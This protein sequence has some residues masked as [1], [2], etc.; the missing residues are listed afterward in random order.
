MIDRILRV[1]DPVRYRKRQL[2]R[3]T[4]AGRVSIGDHSYG[5][6]IL[7]LYDNDADTSLHIG[8]YCSIAAEVNILLG[9]NHP[10]DRITTFPLRHK[11]GLPGAGTDG[12]PSSKGD[13]RIGNDV[14][15]GFGVT[16]V[17]GVKIGDGAVVAAG[18][19]VVGDIPPYAIVGGN[20]AKII[21]MR[22]D[23]VV[24][25]QLMTMRWWDWSDES[26]IQN[27][28]DLVALDMPEAL[29]RLKR[30]TEG[31]YTA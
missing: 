11:L 23:K 20:P 9:G 14:W 6:P 29:S 1:V 22:F 2:R 26:I 4:D 16:I 27:C 25:E 8:K 21:R 5:V 24:V 3:L 30:I 15:I 10:T 13:V 7:H 17:S 18:S 28:S 31:G 12:Y 19:S